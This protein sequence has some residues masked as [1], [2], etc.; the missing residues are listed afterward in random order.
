MKALKA[1]LK[2]NEQKCCEKGEESSFNA[3]KLKTHIFAYVCWIPIAIF[4]FFFNSTGLL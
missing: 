3:K 2:V 1:E 4:D